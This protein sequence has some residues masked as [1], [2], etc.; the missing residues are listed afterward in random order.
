MRVMGYAT[1]VV[2]V[3]KDVERIWSSY[4]R[5]ELCNRG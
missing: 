4:E 2:K 5:V 3:M 1:A